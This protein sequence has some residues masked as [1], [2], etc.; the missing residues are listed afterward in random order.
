VDGQP[1]VVSKNSGAKELEDLRCAVCGIPYKPQTLYGL[2]TSSLWR[3][4]SIVDNQ[5]LAIFCNDCVESH[6]FSLIA[7]LTDIEK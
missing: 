6:K 1:C 5:F 7:K 4:S 3:D 2:I